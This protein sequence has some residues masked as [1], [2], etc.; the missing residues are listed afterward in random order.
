MTKEM[1]YGYAP[2]DLKTGEI[3]IAHAS[4]FENSARASI[5]VAK[6]ESVE[7]RKIEFRVCE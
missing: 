7:V 1:Q 5:Q 2:V 6:Y 3:L 4:E